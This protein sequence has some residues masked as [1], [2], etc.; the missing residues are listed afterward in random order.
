MTS[1][2]DNNTKC[3]IC[4]ENIKKINTGLVNICNNIY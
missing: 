1:F 2:N 4:F 3:V